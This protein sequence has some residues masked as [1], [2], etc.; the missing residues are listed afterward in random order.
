MVKIN[1][2]SNVYFINFLYKAVDGEALEPMCLCFYDRNNKKFETYT[3]NEIK[4]I[5]SWPYNDS[6]SALF[7]MANAYSD[8]GCFVELGWDKPNYIVD[9]YS[10]WRRFSNSNQTN[11]DEKC[12]AADLRSIDLSDCF[13]FKNTDGSC[14]DDFILD[15]E[16]ENVFCCMKI[17]RKVMMFFNFYSDRMVLSEA[18]FGG[19]YVACLYEIEKRGIPVDVEILNLLKNDW[20]KFKMEFIDNVEIGSRIYRD[21]KFITNNFKEYVEENNMEWPRDKNGKLSVDE[22]T[23]K[24]MSLVYPDVEPLRYLKKTLSTMNNFRLSVGIDGRN[25]TCL[26]PFVSKTGRNQPGSSKFIF[27]LPRWMR[28]LIKPTPGKSLCY[29]DWSQQEFGIAAALSNDENMIC[30]YESGDPYMQFAIQAGEAPEGAT[31]HTHG[32]IR[33]KFKTCILAVQYCMGKKALALRLGSTYEEATEL[34]NKHKITYSKYWEW[35]DNILRYALHKRELVTRLGWRMRVINASDRASNSLRNFPMQANGSDMLRLACV[36]MRKQQ[37]S[38]IATVHDAILIEA[39]TSEIDAHR[40][41]AMNIMADVS[42]KLLKNLKLR[43]E[44]KIIGEGDR[45]MDEKGREMWEIVVS[46][47]QPAG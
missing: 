33:A 47:I 11:S 3:E 44:F 40:E 5:K 37:I 8:S 23:F 6:S 10:E 46:K 28:G 2:F 7:V 43:S 16:T 39:N 30:A 41:M 22:D 38:V 42:F 24:E 34:L 31:K 45:Y 13:G 20:D 18:L 26:R 1:A 32:L 25:R 14:F 4:E 15:E 36:E 19:E 9:C 27:G 29:I 21:G 12:W 17:L 35:S